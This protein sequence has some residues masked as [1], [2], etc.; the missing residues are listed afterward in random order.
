MPDV[1]DA[2]ASEDTELERWTFLR[3]GVLGL[4]FLS[5]VLKLL[6]GA[7]AAEEK[8]REQREAE[9]T[10]GQE[11]PAESG[12]SWIFGAGAEETPGQEGTVSEE[13]LL[14]C[15]YQEHPYKQHPQMTLKIA[16]SGFFE[17]VFMSGLLFVLTEGVGLTIY[18]SMSAVM[19]NIAIFF[20]KGAGICAT[21]K[22]VSLYTMAVV[23]FLPNVFL[24]SWLQK[25]MYNEG[26]FPFKDKLGNKVLF[27]VI[28]V[29]ITVASFV[30]RML[31]VYS[32]GYAKSVDWLLTK[33][34]S[35]YRVA[36][37]VAVPPMIDG[38]QS[39]A[40]IMTGSHAKP[41]LADIIES[42]SKM[43]TKMKEL[44]Q[45]CIESEM[46]LDT[47]EKR[48]EGIEHLEYIKRDLPIHRDRQKT[49]CASMHKKNDCLI[50]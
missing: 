41:L 24:G 6:W 20:T 48:L 14:P 25:K 27:V 10:P 22:A 36:L 16:N 9:E 32:G 17:G 42:Q 40:L 11:E 35:H 49:I 37:A 39:T 18:F 3:Y 21:V 46:R 5:Q 4:I 13:P 31:L 19:D 29:C 34:N 7:Q 15:R 23:T 2:C 26:Q 8:A 43:A 44:E 50:L 47:L 28:M 12:W 1:P 33:F 45:R 30:V 38:I